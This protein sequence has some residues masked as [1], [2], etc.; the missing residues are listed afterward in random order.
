MLESSC[1]KVTTETIQNCYR[2]VG[3]VNKAEGLESVEPDD[4]FVVEQASYAAEMG[5]YDGRIHHNG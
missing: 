1:A 2:K 3:F 5:C 4:V